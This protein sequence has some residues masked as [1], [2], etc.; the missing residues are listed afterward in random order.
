MNRRTSAREWSS[1]TARPAKAPVKINRPPQSLAARAS[2][3]HAWA[4]ANR[5]WI[6]ACRL[7]ALRR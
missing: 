1:L 3:D 5:A 2:A 4:V 6:I 7:A